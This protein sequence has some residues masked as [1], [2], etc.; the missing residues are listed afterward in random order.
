MTNLAPKLSDFGLTQS[1]VDTAER[2][3]G[4]Y[5]KAGLILWLLSSVVV[6][7]YPLANGEG[8][9]NSVKLLIALGPLMA[10]LVVIYV[11]SIRKFYRENEKYTKYKTALY[12]HE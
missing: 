4:N 1:D 2:K 6:F 3:R 5:M 8:L 10:L 11:I 7:L 9:G 12:Q